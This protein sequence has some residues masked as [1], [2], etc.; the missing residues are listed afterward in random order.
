MTGIFSYQ[1]ISCPQRGQR[2]RGRTTD[3]FGSA[4]QRTMHTLRK[5]PSTRPSSPAYAMTTGWAPSTLT[6]DLVQENPGRDRDVE[7]LGAG[8]EPDGDSAVRRRVELG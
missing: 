7:R 2:D 5:L 1:R 3:C 4:P 8:R 6:D